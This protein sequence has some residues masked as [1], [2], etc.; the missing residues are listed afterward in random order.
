[1]AEPPKKKRK[2]PALDASFDAPTRATDSPAL[3]QGRTRAVPHEKGQWAAHVYLELELS[4]SFRKTLKEAVAA[5]IS[6]LTPASPVTVHSLIEAPSS[7]PSSRSTTPLVPPGDEKASADIPPPP[8]RLPPPL[9]GSAQPSTAPSASSS[10][11]LHLSLSRP[12]MLQTNQRGEMRAMVGKV[13]KDGIGFSARYASFGVLENDERTRRFLGIE[14]GTGYDE[15]LALVRRLD[16]H[17]FALRLPAYYDEPRFHT[18][19]AWSS[20]TS[21]SALSSSDLPFSDT[22]V[23]VLG[24]KLGKRVRAEELWVGELCVKIGKEVTRFALS[25]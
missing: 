15:M 16:G 7:T 10:T 25:A 24:E 14:I 5:S 21:S 23:Q 13:A 18:S 8:K 20:T 12:L 1:M 11:A 9:P 2:L 22:V 6:S 19:L 4:P 3:H 17:L